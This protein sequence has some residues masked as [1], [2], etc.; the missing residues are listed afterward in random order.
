M[1][2]GWP[3]SQFAE[4]GSRSRA[5]RRWCERSSARTAAPIDA[6][7][8]VVVRLRR[9]SG[10][11]AGQ[12]WCRIR[13]LLNR[14]VALGLRHHP[15]RPHRAPR[16]RHR[17]R[18]RELP[19]ARS[20][21]RQEDPPRQEGRLN[22]LSVPVSDPVKIPALPGAQGQLTRSEIPRILVSTNIAV[23]VTRVAARP[24]SHRKPAT[25]P[26]WPPWRGSPCSSNGPS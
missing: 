4:S 15:H 25:R 24:G 8:V 1:C 2:S 17:H 12:E 7:L 11:L 10:D 23:D 22:H 5:R 13:Y 6:T 14:R 20:R 3:G 19:A 9:P 18:G 16:R 21:G 26:S